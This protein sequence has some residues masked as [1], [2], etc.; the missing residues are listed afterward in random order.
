VGQGGNL[1]QFTTGNFTF[2]DGSVLLI[3]DN[4]ADRSCTRCSLGSRAG[5][6]VG[7]YTQ[8]LG[9][10]AQI[11]VNLVNSSQWFTQAICLVG[12]TCGRSVQRLARLLR[13]GAELPASDIRHRAPHRPGRAHGGCNCAPVG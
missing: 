9:L 12:A 10:Y 7:F 5:R 13:L 3:G 2:A 1:G 8:D 6:I 11:R 4:A